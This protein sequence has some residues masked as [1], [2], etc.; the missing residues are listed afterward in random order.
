MIS[1]GRKLKYKMYP[2]EDGD[3]ELSIREIEVFMKYCMIIVTF[4][5]ENE[6]EKIVSELLDRKLIACA[7]LQDIRSRYVWKGEQVRDNEVL[8]FLKTRA[9][10]YGE[11]EKCVRSLHS[12]EVPEI[13]A[14]PIDK[15]LPEYL[16]WI[17]ENTD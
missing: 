5:D 13:I 16:G 12:Y 15:G 6:A 8:A 4:A 3:S 1:N 2:I 7:Q 14:L 9:Q 10:L 11:V 17:E